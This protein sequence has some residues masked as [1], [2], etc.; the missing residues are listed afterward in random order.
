MRLLDREELTPA[1]SDMLDAAW[2]AFIDAWMNKRDPQVTRVLTVGRRPTGVSHPK[3][4][5]LVKELLARR[6]RGLQPAESRLVRQTNA[7]G[8]YFGRTPRPF[9]SASTLARF[10]RASG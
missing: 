6:A 10:C 2:R 5:E 1:E 8:M 3:L 4:A 9:R 7:A